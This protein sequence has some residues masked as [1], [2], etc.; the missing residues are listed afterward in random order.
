MTNTPHLT[1][2]LSAPN[3]DELQETILALAHSLPDAD[4]I[5]ASR[6]DEAAPRA[7]LDIAARP[8][9]PRRLH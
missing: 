7:E 4:M 2:T 8:V 5:A 9:D 6:I 3:I 1:V